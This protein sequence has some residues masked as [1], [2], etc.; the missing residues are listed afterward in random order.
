MLLCCRFRVVAKIWGA[1]VS[2][3][4]IGSGALRLQS[5]DTGCPTDPRRR[6]PPSSPQH[7]RPSVTTS[8]LLTQLTNQL[9]AAQ[10][11]PSSVSDKLAPNTSPA[12]FVQRLADAIGF[13]CSPQ[14]TL[15]DSSRFLVDL[16]SYFYPDKSYLAVL[17]QA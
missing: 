9:T 5:G 13:I 10:K 11:Q 15:R 8:Q 12:D 17:R 7:A 2:A 6:T 14:N 4:V 3:Q 16:V 1:F